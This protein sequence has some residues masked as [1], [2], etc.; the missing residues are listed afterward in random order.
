MRIF[1][2]IL[3]KSVIK[4]LNA[5]INDRLL[6]LEPTARTTPKQEHDCGFTL[7]WVEVKECHVP[8]WHGVEDGA[9]TSAAG[10]SKVFGGGVLKA[11]C[12]F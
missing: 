4:L 1:S 7:G 6:F 12:I 8:L 5:S 11:Y 3:L 9:V 10:R 2:C